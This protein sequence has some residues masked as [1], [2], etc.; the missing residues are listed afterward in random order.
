M[1][2][3]Q[4]HKSKYKIPED[5]KKS[6][7]AETR[8]DL[9]DYTLEDKDGKMNPGASGKKEALVP[10]NINGEVIDDSENIRHLNKAMVDFH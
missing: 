5:F 4:K 3:T 6:Q 2:K 7:K 9:K 1:A 10:R 8:K